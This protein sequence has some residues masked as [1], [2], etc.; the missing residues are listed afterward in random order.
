MLELA[1]RLRL[2]YYRGLLGPVT[3]FTIT[4]ERKRRPE[5]SMQKARNFKT[6]SSNTNVIVMKF[7]FR[8]KSRCKMSSKLDAKQKQKPNRAQLARVLSIFSMRIRWIPRFHFLPFQLLL[9]AFNGCNEVLWGLLDNWGFPKEKTF[10]NSKTRP[11]QSGDKNGGSRQGEY[12]R[13]VE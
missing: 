11:S 13:L 2:F 3:T 6:N 10:Q 5:D 12:I 1:G 8:A 4:K 9:T 7:V